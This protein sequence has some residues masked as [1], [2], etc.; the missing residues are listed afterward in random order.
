MI[1]HDALEFVVMNGRKTVDESVI[2]EV[3]RRIS[4]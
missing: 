3:A 4:V 2:N 1:C